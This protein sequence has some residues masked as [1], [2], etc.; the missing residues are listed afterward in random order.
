MIK[1][2]EQEKLKLEDETDKIEVIYE[3]HNKKL[4]TAQEKIMFA[5]EKRASASAT[6]AAGSAT[7]AAGSSTSASGFA[8]EAENWAK[9][10]NGIVESTDYSSK[11][12]A[13]GGTD[14]TATGTELNFM[15]GDASISTGITLAA[16]DGV[17]INDG[18]SMLQAEVSDFATYVSGNIT[19][20][21]VGTDDLAANAVDGTKIN[22]E[23]VLRINCVNH[24]R[25]KKDIDFLFK[26]IKEVGLKAEKFYLKD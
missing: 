6:A 19:D 12:W 9:K 26:V 5:R 14:V 23:H 11:A 17:V 8:D 2:T 16:G 3:N 13:I 1:I 18:G 10:T 7:A 15:D 21:A 24:R 20:G 22:N 25:N 4:K